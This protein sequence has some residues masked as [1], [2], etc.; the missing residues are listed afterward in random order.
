MAAD[1]TS[2]PTSSPSL[3]PKKF[4]AMIVSM[5]MTTSMIT[6]T[7]KT[8]WDRVRVRVRVRVRGRVRVRVRVRVRGEGEGWG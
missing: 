2:W 5:K 7:A 8:A 4:M 6:V 3:P 1:P